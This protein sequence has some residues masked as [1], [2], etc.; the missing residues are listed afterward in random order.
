M[1]EKSVR[2]VVEAC[3]SFSRTGL[4]LDCKGERAQQSRRQ[5]ADQHLLSLH[6]QHEEKQRAHRAD[7]ARNIG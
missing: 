4:S 7:T 1:I 3:R 2:L 5:A 6:S